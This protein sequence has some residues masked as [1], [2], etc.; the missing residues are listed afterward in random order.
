M[1]KIS[2]IIAIGLVLCSSVLAIGGALLS[3]DTNTV[4]IDKTQQDVLETKGLTDIKI[5]EMNC[6]GTTCRSCSRTTEG[7]GMGC[8]GFAQ[9]KCTNIDEETSECLTWVEKSNAE[10]QEAE[11]S[12]YKT[13]WEGIADTIVERESRNIETKFNKGQVTVTESK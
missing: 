11:A 6:D 13:R 9:Q 12:A 2:I 1:K 3:R 4:S 10:L 8:V 7:Y 5:S